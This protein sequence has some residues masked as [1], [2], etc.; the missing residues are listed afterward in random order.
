MQLDPYLLFN[1]NCKEAFTFYEKLLGGKIEMMMT[2]GESPMKDQVKPEW[3]DKIIHTAMKV[4]DRVLMASDAP[5]EHYEPMQ[6]FSVSINV[7]EPAE[8]ER[9]FQALAEN[10]QVRMPLQKT[11]FS[12]SFGMLVDRFGTPWMVN[13]EGPK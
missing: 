11:F 8:A 4:G 7:K 13:C 9:I 12:A 5:P 2:H 1:G 3:R 10:G 6:G